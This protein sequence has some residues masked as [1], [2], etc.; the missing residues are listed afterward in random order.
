MREKIKNVQ[1]VI[2]KVSLRQELQVDKLLWQMEYLWDGF[3]G[4]WKILATAVSICAQIKKLTFV[5]F[6]MPMRV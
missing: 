6:R 1:T 5:M 4:N 2:H 3:T